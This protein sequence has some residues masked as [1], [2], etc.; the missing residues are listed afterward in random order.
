MSR[1]LHNLVQRAKGHGISNAPV[2]SARPAPLFSVPLSPLATMPA[3]DSSPSA[4]NPLPANMAPTLTASR[5]NFTLLASPLAPVRIEPTAMP[6]P[7]PQANAPPEIVP[8]PAVEVARIAPHAVVA[9]EA[10]SIALR[11]I[12]DLNTQVEPSRVEPQ[13]EPSPTAPRA[14]RS[15][16]LPAVRPPPA[17]STQAVVPTAPPLLVRAPVTPPVHAAQARVSAQPQ[18]SAGEV[19]APDATIASRPSEQ[20]GITYT[21]TAEPAPPPERARPIAAAPIEK[22]PIPQSIQVEPR[23]PVALQTAD[24]RKVAPVTPPAAPPLQ[25]TPRSPDGSSPV[26]IMPNVPNAATAPTPARPVK[27]TVEVHIGSLDVR[28]DRP[29][30]PKSMLSPAPPR[31]SFDDYVARRSYREAD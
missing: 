25:I 26:V 18:Q 3:P 6:E 13:S 27:R 1:Y 16:D 10:S 8:M 17:Q 14:E 21:S 24:I 2:V 30:H 28:F 15:A 20:V 9:P 7:T 29:E 11:P 31:P 23:A 22:S 5:T 4:L 12:R 19:R